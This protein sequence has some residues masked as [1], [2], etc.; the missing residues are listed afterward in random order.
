MNRPPLTAIYMT[1]ACNLAQRSTC[2]RSK[3]GAVITTNDLEQVLA[4]GYNGNAKGFPNKCDTDEPGACGC[5]HA[6]INAQA[7]CGRASRDKVLF[8]TLSPCVM[9]AKL[10]INSGYSTVYYF[11]EYRKLDGVTLLKQAGIEV[12]SVDIC[13]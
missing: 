7:K 2:N 3:V 13:A 10:L 4:I 9:C 12:C 1:L 8:T 6:E 11:E 5:L